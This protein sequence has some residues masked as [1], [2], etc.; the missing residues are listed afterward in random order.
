[1]PPGIPQGAPAPAAI[2][3]DSRL[4]DEKTAKEAKFAYDGSN[5]GSTWRSDAWDY[6]A[7][8]C[9]T[10][11]PWLTWVEQQGS[12]EI[13]GA[14]MTQTAMSGDL[15]T[16]LNPYVL[17]HHLWGSLQHGLHGKARQVFKGEKGHDGFN[18][19]GILILEINSKTDCRRHGIRT[20]V[21]NPPKSQ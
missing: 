12:T 18:V 19:W 15:M 21:Q 11:G 1:M 16:E 5:Q 4:F 14:S 9:P 13:T 6:I 3:Y 20:R 2:T 17:S 8:R 7:S 10:A